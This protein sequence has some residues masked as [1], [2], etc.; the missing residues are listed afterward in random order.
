MQE[1]IH[2]TKKRNSSTEI[3]EGHTWLSSTIA[4]SSVDY[5]WSK[6]QHRLQP[7]LVLSRSMR[8][9]IEVQGLSHSP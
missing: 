2:K 4:F 7:V 9:F 8:L 5:G 6:A 1:D 3:L